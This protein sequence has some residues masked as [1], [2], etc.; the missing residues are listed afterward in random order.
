M[1]KDNS[2]LC[3]SDGNGGIAYFYRFNKDTQNFDQI[4][5]KEYPSQYIQSV[6]IS[7]KKNWVGVSYSSFELLQGLTCN[8]LLLN[9]QLPS[10]IYS[11]FSF[12]E[13]YLI[14][15]RNGFV[16]AYVNSH[17]NGTSS[18]NASMCETCSQGCLL[19]TNDTYCEQCASTYI[20]SQD[21][22]SCISCDLNQI[23]TFFDNYE[24]KKC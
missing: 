13:Q 12:D 10:S 3:V 6:S 2:Y 9:Q 17:Y 1:T 5:T 4:F 24:C 11:K 19:C 14:L 15:G 16:E 18:E 23:N 20:L 7:Q 21:H 8:N 22:S